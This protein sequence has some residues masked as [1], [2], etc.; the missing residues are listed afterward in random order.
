[1]TAAGILAADGN[2]VFPVDFEWTDLPATEVF[3]IDKE[4]I[5]LNARYR[6]KILAGSNAS[7]ADVPMF[8]LMLF[9]LL[10]DDVDK[11]GL[12]VGRRRHLDQLNRLLSHALK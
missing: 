11:E 3:R 12:S 4:V 5:L 2:G 8:K 7:G 10:K 9:L 1:M 6:R